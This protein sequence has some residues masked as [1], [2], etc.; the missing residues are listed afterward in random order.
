MIFLGG[1]KWNEEFVLLLIVILNHYVLKVYNRFVHV[2]WYQPK[3]HIDKIKEEFYCILTIKERFFRWSP[4]INICE[5]VSLVY[6][7]QY[8]IRFASDPINDIRVK[9][10]EIDLMGNGLQLFDVGGPSVCDHWRSGR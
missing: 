7:E 6:D 8:H 1:G 2:E 3:Y 9:T 4:K 10:S 5:F